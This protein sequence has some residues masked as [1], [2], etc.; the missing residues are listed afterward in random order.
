MGFV[1]LDLEGEAED[2]HV[3]AICEVGI[4]VGRLWGDSSG[5]GMRRVF[6]LLR[7]PGSVC[8]A[9]PNNER[10]ARERMTE[11]CAKCCCFSYVLAS[12]TS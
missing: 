11:S 2:D 8:A 3:Y 6:P 7:G 12:R 5:G 9:L 4:D 10:G 1:A